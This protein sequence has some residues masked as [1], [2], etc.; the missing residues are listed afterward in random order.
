MTTRCL[1][2]YCNSHIQL[3]PGGKKES[4]PR[5]PSQ[6]MMQPQFKLRSAQ[7]KSLL[8]QPGQW[9]ASETEFTFCLLALSFAGLPILGLCL[10]S[11]R[12]IFSRFRD[13]CNLGKRRQF[14]IVSLLWMRQSETLQRRERQSGV[15]V[16]SDNLARTHGQK[17]V[18][19]VYL[20]SGKYIWILCLWEASSTG[21]VPWSV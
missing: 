11:L 2:C 21:M 12:T 9:A 17:P 7:L 3:S 13:V 20:T 18:R 1:G 4:C 10:D 8:L 15:H 19:K 14:V 5:S 16:C 6:E